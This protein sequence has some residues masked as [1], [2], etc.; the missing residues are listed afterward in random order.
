MALRALPSMDHR[1]YYDPPSSSSSSSLAGDASPPGSPRNMLTNSGNK[2]IMSSRWMRKG[3]MYAWGPTYEDVKADQRLRERLTICLE[4]LMP[5]SAAD[6]GVPAPQNIVELEAKRKSRKRKRAEEKEMVLPHLKSPSPPISTAELAPML[7]IPQTY[8]DIMLSPS[9]RHSLGNDSMEM[10]LQRTAGELLDGEN[11]LMQSL[12][13]L[14]EVLRVRA[15][16][17]PP[18]QEIEAPVPNGKNL[19][20]NG[21]AEEELMKVDT[22]GRSPAPPALLAPDGGP[23]IPPL[24]HISDTDNLWRVTQELLQAQPQPTIVFSVTPSGAALPSGTNDPEPT[25][26]PIHHLFT[27]RNGIT[28]NA[29]PHP[30]H[31]C[32]A[33]PPSHQAYPQPVKYNLDLANQC[34]AVDDALERIAELLADCIEYK[35][36]LEEARDRVADVARARKKV[37][38]V[39]KERAGQELDRAES[40]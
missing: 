5:E 14:R 2:L 6:L 3:K 37:W 40:K 12:G 39:V 29:I 25:L 30:S 1:Q 32:Y 38:A 11:G 28:V 21:H 26:T 10:G 34:R 35:E 24:P 33:Y 31:P 18:S 22:P 8:L 17:V 19:E 4:Q 16:D 23:R 27:C 9:M 36:R 7:A 15:R 13:R 20:P